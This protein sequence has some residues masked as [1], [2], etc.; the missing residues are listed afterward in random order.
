MFSCATCARTFRLE[1][2]LL[3]HCKDKFGHKPLT[4][5]ATSATTTTARPAAAPAQEAGPSTP[6]AM[7]ASSTKAKGKAAA[8]VHYECQPCCLLFTDKAAY[9]DHNQRLHP[10]PKAAPKFRC[11]PCGVEFSSSEAL[12]LHC[13]NS[14]VHPK[15]PK[16]NSAF[17]DQTQLKLHMV[18]HENMFSCGPCG[19]EVKISERQQHYKESP[20]HPICFVCEEGFHDDADL[21]K[22]LATAHLATR[23][24][25]CRRQFRSADELQNHYLVSPMHPHCAVC[26]IGFV[27]D[28]A[29]DKH[30]ELNHPRPP[31]QVEPGSSSTV[32]PAQSFPVPTSSLETQR[33]TQSSP[34][35]QRSSLSDVAL[36]MVAT[37]SLAV[38][39]EKSELGDDSYETI[40][41]SSHVQRAVSEPTV[42][43]VSS[44]GPSSVQG[45]A[46]MASRSPTISEL[47]FDDMVRRRNVMRH[48]DSESTLS[49]RSVSSSSSMSSGPGYIRNP[50]F[51]RA[52]QQT[53]F[54]ETSVPQPA[55]L[56]PSSVVSQRA[57]RAPTPMQHRASTAT[58]VERVS[59]QHGSRASS[60]M[61]DV[62]IATPI[63]THSRS[64]SSTPDR[65]RTPLPV[66]SSASRP[67]SRVSALSMNSQPAVSLSQKPS[68]TA[69]EPPSL[70]DSE[71]TIE[72]PNNAPKRKGAPRQ[73][74]Q[75]GA[76]SFHCR[77]CMHDPCVAPMATMCGHIF[78]TAC[79]LKELAKTGSCPVC[80]KLFLLRLHVE[81]D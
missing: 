42:P 69:V 36:A 71:G 25:Q 53:A 72:A 34:L 76:V 41:A 78:C 43:T 30:M 40:E 74:G 55:S 45:A 65:V 48:P 56:R 64:R 77:S 35:V 49:L 60:R 19:R 10:P 66:R 28:V 52:P 58:P 68:M 75:G 57:S 47:S 44:I 29:C 3:Q 79:I 38:A 50:A 2:A 81:A 51:D 73:N 18:V 15:C 59:E 39:Q 12:S 16:C 27:D 9:D 31:P 63:P 54:V 80:G 20:N 26:E 4:A 24:S 8:S 33:S 46:M 23:C 22:H 61:M 67:L 7:P 1:S 6:A 70:S 14:F 32:Q 21:D 11:P 13:R 17:I 37:A 5:S 62:P